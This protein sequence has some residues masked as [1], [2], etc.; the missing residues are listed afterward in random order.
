M[1]LTSK[2]RL[3]PATGRQNL[4]GDQ[5]WTVV[6]Y[7]HGHCCTGALLL[8]SPPPLPVYHKGN[9]PLLPHVLV[10]KLLWSGTGRAKLNLL[11]HEL[12]IN[13]P[14]FRSDI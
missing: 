7:I 10:T 12:K 11:K 5:E 9:S 2:G 6:L 8:V 3:L 4:E 14:S 1:L 13:P